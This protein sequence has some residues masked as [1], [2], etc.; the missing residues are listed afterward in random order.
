M[1]FVSPR[2]PVTM[3][4]KRALSLLLTLAI[5][6]N[7]MAY[8]A[9]RQLDAAKAKETL[10]KRGI[11]NGVRITQSDGTDVTGILAAIHD[12]SF[13][14]TP[15]QA[16]MPTTIPYAQVTGIHNDKSI[17]AQMGKGRNNHVWRYIRIAAVVGLLITAMVMDVGPFSD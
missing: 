8:A 10:I 3:H 1:R 7:A 15:L 6:G 5:F 12:D 11:G 14:V 13:E 4:I 9:P 2:Y 16:S 17:G